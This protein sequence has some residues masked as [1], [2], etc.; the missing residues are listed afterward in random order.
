MPRLIKNTASR[1]WSLLKAGLFVVFVAVFVSALV[2]PSKASASQSARFEDASHIKIKDSGMDTFTLQEVQDAATDAQIDAQS[3]GEDG[4]VLKAVYFF[5]PAAN[6]GKRIWEAGCQ[7]CYDY[8][9]SP[10]LTVQA[11]FPVYVGAGEN[12]RL[13]Y[14]LYEIAPRAGVR[15][16]KDL[17]PPMSEPAVMTFNYEENG[18]K[19]PEKKDG[20]VICSME[21]WINCYENTNG[22]RLITSSTFT[23]AERD[24]LDDIISKTKS[25]FKST[26]NAIKDSCDGGALGFILCPIQDAMLKVVET[27]NG[28]LANILDINTSGFQN[29][30]LQRASQNIL[31][32]ANAIY[33]LIFLVIIF[34]NGLSIGIDSYTLKKMVPRLV[35]AIILSQFAYFL[36]GAFIEFGNV[37]GRTVTAFFVQ[38]VPESANGVGLGGAVTLGV[39]TGVAILL[40]LVMLLVIIVAFLVVLG[41]LALR[42]AALYALILVA[43][44]AFAA[45]VLPNTK[46][47]FDLW[48]KN[49]LKLV[50]M[51]PIIMAITAGATFL[52]TVMIAEDAPLVIQIIGALL[53]F[54]GFLMVPKAFKW[55]GSLMA[56]TGGKVSDW[57]AGK[58]KGTYQKSAKEGSIAKAKGKG[59]Q[60][61]GGAAT[62]MPV[63]GGAAGGA[64]LKRG[65]AARGAASSAEKDYFKNFSDEDLGK[66]IAATKGK[67]KLA[68][69]AKGD[70][71]RRIS[72][73][74]KDQREY[75]S[76]T[77]TV[78][79]VGAAKLEKLQAFKLGEVGV[80]A[81]ETREGTYY[82]PSRGV[83]TATVKLDPT[84]DNVEVKGSIVDISGATVVGVPT[85]PGGTPVSTNLPKSG[86]VPPGSGPKYSG[87]DP[88]KRSSFL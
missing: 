5:S 1:R 84:T 53:P 78:D 58:A 31:G 59:L 61:A 9:F 25:T 17:K 62:K 65:A 74:A 15:W 76:R 2:S 77:G 63:F 75:F 37:L 11:G 55:S 57:T 68:G 73:K 88:S 36:T 46:K 13:M 8:Y 27:L 40:I 12:K 71:D 67:G 38:L 32:L 43:P 24:K 22:G 81:D 50:M 69:V 54:I 82:D 87:Y 60:I 33:A 56:A 28:W 4:T 80:D 42:W 21:Q 51:F 64:L 19:T 20:K 26:Q 86:S 30:T 6:L 49:L 35:A 70:L 83:V 3:S 29:D 72:E 23:D 18:T 44:L 16:D 14:P 34:A 66:Y 79:T 47:L 10:T 41:V 39:L 45:M 85:P 7:G 52:S 48:W